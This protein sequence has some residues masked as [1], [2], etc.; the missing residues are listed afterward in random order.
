MNRYEANRF[1][2]APMLDWTDRH[3]RFFWRLMSK[4]AMLYTEMVTT[5]AII[6]SK[7]D[8]LLYNEEEHPV[9][10]QL[11]GS[12]PSDLAICAKKAQEYGY[13]EI[14]LNIGC[15]SDRVQ[16][17]GFGASLMGNA[18]LVADCFKAMADA[19]SIPVTVKCRI[20]IDNLDSYE[21]LTDFVKTVADA[22]CDHFIIHARKA[23]LS[24]LS[25]KE[26]RDIPP[27]NYPRVYQIK[28]DFPDLYVSINGGI[29]DLNAAKDHLKEVD[30]V[31]LGRAIYQNP[32]LL[33]SVD[34]EIFG[35]ESAPEITRDNVMEKLMIYAEKIL[36]KGERL[37]NLTRHIL[38]LYTGIPG[39]RTFRR[40]L[41]Q[42]AVRSGADISVLKKAWDF[43]N[44][45]GIMQREIEEEWLKK[46]SE[47][48]NHD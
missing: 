29:S 9:A 41:S 25:P 1:S 7:K 15:P 26:N 24:G 33:A 44:S 13:D 32:F 4:K 46:G 21:F 22:G 18:P 20:G 8:H 23:W 43:V 38:D 28:K 48:D 2:T 36:Q 30:G 5:G 40:I 35:D 34:R 42:E 19:T 12:V 10:L 3:C 45:A 31:M 39:A 14:N 27:L 6:Y 47:K 11:G 37:S 17:G 16:N